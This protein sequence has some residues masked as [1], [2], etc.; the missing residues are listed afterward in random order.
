[1]TSRLAALRSILDV[2]Q[3]SLCTAD[4]IFGFVDGRQHRWRR[5][6]NVFISEN[7]EEGRESEEII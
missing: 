4:F 1:M 2:S 7:L 6:E 5:G 3:H